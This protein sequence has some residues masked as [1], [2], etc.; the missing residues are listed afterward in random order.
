MGQ[1]GHPTPAPAL[2]LTPA[3][4]TQLLGPGRRGVRGP[5]PGWGGWEGPI[6]SSCVSAEPRAPPRGCAQQAPFRLSH[7]SRSPLPPDSR[8]ALDPG[9]SGPKSTQA[10]NAPAPGPVSP[11]GSSLGSSRES[12][13]LESDELRPPR[14]ALPASASCLASGITTPLMGVFSATHISHKGP[15]WAGAGEWWWSKPGLQ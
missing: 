8:L 5:G 9:P 4:D 10:P 7:P 6:V 2:G 15:A 3:K 12:L 13:R 1:E 14:P 11:P